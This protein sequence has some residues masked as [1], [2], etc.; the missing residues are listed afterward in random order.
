MSDKLTVGE[1]VYKISGDM[2]NL[3]TEL[4]KAETEITNLKSAMEKTSTSTE[5]ISKKLTTAAT[6]LK[7]FFAGFAIKQVIDFGREAVKQ[8]SEQ[9]EQQTKLA[10]VLRTS[11]NATDEQIASVV[12]LANEMENVGVISKDVTIAAQAQLATY[13]LSTDAIKT[14]TPALLDYLAAERGM[15]A[16][17]DDAIGLTNGLAQAIQ[18]NYASLSK[19][20]FILDDVTKKQI[21]NGN[22]TE[23]VTAI[24]DVLNST[25]EGYN[26][27]LA[28]T[29]LGTQV[30]A[31]RVLGDFK[32]DLGFALMPAIQLVTQGFIDWASKV[33][34]SNEALQA[35]APRIN[36]W[37][38]YIY[39]A[40]NFVIAMGK[41]IVLVVKAIIGFGDAMIKGGKLAFQFAKNTVGYV[42]N[43]KE[44]FLTLGKA[45]Q[46]LFSGD[47]DGALDEFKKRVTTAFSDTGDAFGDFVKSQ[48]Y[49]GKQLVDQFDSVGR[50]MVEAVD[51][52]N[53][54]PITAD[55]LKA[56]DALNNTGDA[57]GSAGEG[58]DEAK[59]KLEQLQN[60]LVDLIKA[61]QDTRKELE[62]DLTGAFKE[63]ADSIKGNFED[64]VTSLAQ[65]VVN[66]EQR[67]KELNAEIAEAQKDADANAVTAREELNDKIAKADLA[68]SDKLRKIK[69]DDKNAAEKQ[70]EAQLQYQRQ[71]AEAQDEY[72]KKTSGLDTNGAERVAELQAEI[73]KEEEILASRE[74]FEQR[75]ADR[76][77][78]IRAKLEAAGIDATKAGLDDLL[79]AKSLQEQ[80][81]EERRRAT[82]NEFQLFEEDQTKKLQIL[83]DN[84]IAEVKLTEEKIQK[85]K[86][87]EADLTAFLI[88]EDASRLDS[89][90]AW[91]QATIAKY[92][93]VAKSLQN[94]ISLRAQLG[95]ISAASAAVAPT[96]PASAASESTASQSINNSKTVN[97]P[98]TINAQGASSAVDYRAISREMGFEIS[99]M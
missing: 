46:K 48:D 14:L 32:D 27:A 40:T 71:I 98:V 64:S 8:A 5:G 24:V 53:F 36:V 97:A 20:G 50:S 95:E 41:T 9:L 84:F 7:T 76:I 59:K 79:N 17:K 85:Q 6:A 35:G 26:E 29:F 78:E 30:R 43:V 10:S 44:N 16:T 80:I 51:A 58:A 72:A 86:D 90:D 4:K 21:E 45:L 73:K 11:R 93:E 92:G 67:I 47:F 62:G 37:G 69:A 87:Y 82:L 38:K 91:A 13:D 63:F 1:L 75:Q 94:V 99:R 28:G 70:A 2:D 31:Q 39:Q 61:S 66:A 81:D 12:Q 52:V 34:D 65:I 18:G 49:W 89:T 77:A 25:Y 68:L 19:S 15:N 3:K 23:R 88:N 74:G 22:E 33:G 60:K 42:T 83:T 96:T 54:K 56:Y 57:F 55:A